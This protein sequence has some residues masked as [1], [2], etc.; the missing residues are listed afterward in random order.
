MRSE[1]IGR[2]IKSRQQGCKMVDICISKPKIP[3]W[4]NLVNFAGS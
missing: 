4:A 2:E 1:F 3:V